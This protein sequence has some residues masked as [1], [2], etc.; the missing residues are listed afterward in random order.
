MDE[1]EA[2]VSCPLCE[3]KCSISCPACLGAKTD[4]ECCKETGDIQCLLCQGDDAVKVILHV[5]EVPIPDDIWTLLW[6]DK[7]LT[8]GEDWTL[9]NLFQEL[10][11]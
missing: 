4:C 5:N 11:A 9:D 1:I 3:G 7:C 10:R 2:W 6:R 8:A